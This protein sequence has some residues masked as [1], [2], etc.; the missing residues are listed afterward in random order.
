MGRRLWQ[1]ALPPPERYH[2]RPICTRGAQGTAAP[3]VPGW[4]ADGKPVV[5][6]ENW[7][8]WRLVRSANSFRVVAVADQFVISRP[9]GH[10]ARGVA[11]RRWECPVSGH[12]AGGSATWG[13][14]IMGAGEFHR[15]ATGRPP[16][17]HRSTLDPDRGYYGEASGWPAGRSG[18]GLEVE[19]KCSVG[20]RRVTNPVPERLATTGQRVW[21][22]RQRWRHKAQTVRI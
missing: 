17:P 9:I 14:P 13:K 15:S 22:R 8:D 18:A 12:T 21:R 4:H 16:E 7:S 10:F 1:H 2:C 6:S 19:E 20:P 3:P 5:P 11:V